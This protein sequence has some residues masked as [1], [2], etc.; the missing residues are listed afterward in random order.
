MEPIERVPLLSS[1]L[2][3]VPA[4]PSQMFPVKRV[5]WGKDV[6]SAQGIVLSIGR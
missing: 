3:D 4:M 5:L 1:E 6:G 2:D